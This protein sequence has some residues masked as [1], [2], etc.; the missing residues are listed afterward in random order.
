MAATRA[1]AIL[2]LLA[3]GACAQLGLEP[4]PPTDFAIA[5]EELELDAG[6]EA[7]QRTVERSLTESPFEFGS[8]SVVATEGGELQTYNFFPCQG[9]QGVCS[10]SPQGPA[11]Q[12]YRSPQ[13][14]VLTGLHGRTFW[15]GYGG[16]GYVQQGG[17]YVSLAWNARPLGT[18]NGG[19]PSMETPY[20][21]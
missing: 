9:G 7:W 6:V 3:L 1:A 16:D 15:L 21:H 19:T 14:Y 20:P 5:P 8:M 4:F 17:R 2:G 10:G 12:L 11:G 18:G 13:H